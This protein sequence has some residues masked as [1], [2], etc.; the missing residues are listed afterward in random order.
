MRAYVMTTGIVF[1]VLAAI[2]VWRFI[3]E[4]SQVARNPF[5]LAITIVA[6]GLCLWAVRLLRP[7]RS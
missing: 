3:E 6:A 2:H 5:F 1:G 7:A 4:G